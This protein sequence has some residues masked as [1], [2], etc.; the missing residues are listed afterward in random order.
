M[1]IEADV[2]DDATNDDKSFNLTCEIGVTEEQRIAFNAKMKGKVFLRPFYSDK[3]QFVEDVPCTMLL[4]HWEEEDPE[5]DLSPFT[6][7]KTAEDYLRELWQFCGSTGQLDIQEREQGPL[8]SL[9]VQAAMREADAKLQ[10][11]IEDAE[12]AQRNR[13]N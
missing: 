4:A 3:S 12:Q 1:R 5:E 13:M 10:E 7:K 6:E 2:T 8:L 11:I 9:E